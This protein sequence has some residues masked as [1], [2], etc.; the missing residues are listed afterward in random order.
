[1]A[2]WKQSNYGVS[3]Q[4]MIRTVLILVLRIIILVIVPF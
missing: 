2:T 3:D 4:H 1:M